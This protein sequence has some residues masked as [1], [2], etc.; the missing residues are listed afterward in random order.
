MKTRRA[1]TAAERV[2]CDERRDQAM[3]FVSSMMTRREGDCSW[4]SQRRAVERGCPYDVGHWMEDERQTIGYVLICL[5]VVYSIHLVISADAFSLL[6]EAYVEAL[7]GT[8]AQI[9]IIGGM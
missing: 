5:G 9:E 8:S 7:K 1:E 3:G 6:R 2:S 4:L